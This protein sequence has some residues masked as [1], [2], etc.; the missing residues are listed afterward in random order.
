MRAFV[1]QAIQSRKPAPSRLAGSRAEILTRDHR[2]DL[3]PVSKQTIAQ[4]SAR[5]GA[6]LNSELP[7]DGSAKAPPPHFRWDF[8]R[9]PVFSAVPARIQ[10]KL[11]INRPGDEYE[12]EAD[13]LAEQVTQMATPAAD[14]R[15]AAD[16]PPGLQRQHLQRKAASPVDFGQAISPA[17][18]DVLRSPGQPLDAATRAFMQPRFG[19][20]FSRVRVHSGAEAERSAREIAAKA[21]TVG[22]DIVF[23]ANRFAPSTDEGRRLLAHELTHVIQQTRPSSNPVPDAIANPIATSVRYLPSRM[24]QRDDDTAAADPWDKL[25]PAVRKDA[26]QLWD[27]CDGMIG[28]LDEAQLVHSSMLRDDWLNSLRKLR[29]DI[30]GLDSEGKLRGA[31]NSLGNFE[32]RIGKEIAKFQK[33][34][35]E[36]NARYRDIDRWLL[37]TSVKSTDSIE[38]EKYLKS[39]YERTDAHIPFL[40]TE[41]DYAE[42]KNALDKQEYIRVGSLRGARIRAKQLKEMMNT[43]AD[44]RRRGE[45][46]DKF[47][48]GWSDRVLE[49]AT[50]LDSF[51]KLAR[52]AGREYAGELDDLRKQ[53]L[54]K[55]EETSKVAPPDKSWLEKGADLIEGGVEAV[56]GI[57]VEAAKEAVDLVQI[58]LHFVTFGKYEPVFISDMA[59]AAEQG[60]TTGDLLI[61]FVRGA[62]GT[63]G[64]FLQACRDGDW[65]AI[66]RESVNLYLLAKT[67]KEAPETI[68]K[69]PEAVKKL[70]ELLAKTR[71]SL[72]ILR[73]RTV[74]LGLKNE[75]RLTPEPPSQPVRRPAAPAPAAAPPRDLTVKQGGGEGHGVPTGQLSSTDR[76]GTTTAQKGVKVDASHPI[77]KGKQP[78]NDPPVPPH[79]QVA[80]VAVNAPKDVPHGEHI[81][82]GQGPSVPGRGADPA[83]MA[84]TPKPSGVDPRKQKKSGPP[85]EELDPGEGETTKKRR[86]NKGADEDLPKKEK[87]SDSYTKAELENSPELRARLPDA[88]HR[89]RYM[90]WLE[91]SHYGRGHPHIIPA[92]N[93][94]PSLREFSQ[95]TGIALQPQ[96]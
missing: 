48:P 38:A 52:E 41:E 30:E 22:N 26:Q 43:V 80:K 19:Q 77:F 65:K 51:V 34:W 27:D 9:I 79:R 92:K 8:S 39:I 90:E 70:P 21:Y 64:R 85:A 31:R 5:P 53:L 95:D 4:R 61:G 96:K 73:Q 47:I 89:R 74:A 17:V 42:L 72:R 60:A 91:T 36:T 86:K 24:L 13:R 68:K 10:T 3:I 50:Y 58:N 23:G 6:Q 46:A 83:Q 93:L 78:A 67:M 7:D 55:R 88:D 62:L 59:A 16:A 15:D 75:G 29:S 54:E 28:R 18:H 56:V 12:R 66:G 84:R 49:E 94:E 71:D 82:T 76:P 87:I 20:D 37:S 40:T 11:E 45:E 1:R 33:E 81:D 57:F 63:P 2:D 44:L 32:S 69:I 25:S 14:R 35:V